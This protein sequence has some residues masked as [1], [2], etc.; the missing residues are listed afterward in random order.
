MQLNT[1][2]VSIPTGGIIPPVLASSHDFI[3]P[4]R[5]MIVESDSMAPTLNIGDQVLFDP[6]IRRITGEGV[7]VFRLDGLLLPRR[8]TFDGRS[9]RIGT[10]N[11]AYGEAVPVS[12]GSMKGLDIAGRITWMGRQI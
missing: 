8:V 5:M 1:L 10:D 4:L 7:Y 12:S 2:P 3:P 9:W 11:R 6:S